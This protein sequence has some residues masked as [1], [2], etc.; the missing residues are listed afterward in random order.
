MNRTC[1]RLA[2]MAI[3]AMVQAGLAGPIFAQ[4]SP[5]AAQSEATGSEPETEPAPPTEAALP[6]DMPV[7]YITG[8]EV[9]RTATEPRIDI[10]RVTGLASSR[11]WSFA[12]LVPTSA[13]TP[14]DG[15]LDLQLIAT[16]PE[17]SQEADGFVPVSAVLVLD[18]GDPYKGIRVRGAENAV[19]VTPIP[20]SNTATITVNDCH[21][22][23]GKKFV[24]EGQSDAGQQGILRQKDFPGHLRLIARSSGIGG[25]MTNPNRLSLILGSDG[26]IV[27]A[28]WE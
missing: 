28:F 23:L 25:T 16:T 17:Q 9:L 13:R 21:D 15:I 11:G 7:L 5:P 22:C 12:Q 10:V 24:A 2:V 18:Q 6:T 27:E 4:G 1:C 26:T 8:V 3:A 14:T 20:G 19:E